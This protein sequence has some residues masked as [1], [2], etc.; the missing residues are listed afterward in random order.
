VN[1][2]AQEIISVTQKFCARMAA[3]QFS[4]LPK[5]AIDEGKCSVLDWLGCALAQNHRVRL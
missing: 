4:D 2:V 5:K 3:A 1:E